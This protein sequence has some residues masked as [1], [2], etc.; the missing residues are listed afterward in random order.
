[1]GINWESFVGSAAKLPFGALRIGL[2]FNPSSEAPGQLWSKHVETVL[3]ASNQACA[4]LQFSKRSA[5]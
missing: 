2:K 3:E 1:V 5:E 4:H